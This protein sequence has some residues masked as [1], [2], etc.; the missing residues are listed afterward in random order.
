[1]AFALAYQLTRQHQSYE[2]VLW[3]SLGVAKPAAASLQLKYWS[4][5]TVHRHTHALTS[6]EQPPLPLQSTHAATPLTAAVQTCHQAVC[7]TSG[8][9]D[10]TSA[11]QAARSATT[12]ARPQLRL[13]T[14]WSETSSCLQLHSSAVC[15][16]Q[17]PR[18]LPKPVTPPCTFC[19][20]HTPVAMST[21]RPP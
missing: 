14:S 2:V 12:E 18:C 19:V 13:R 17:H 10:V 21:T 15:N 9:P 7:D 6:P 16:P 5:C 11:E 3:N 20:A 8:T 1:M 4:H